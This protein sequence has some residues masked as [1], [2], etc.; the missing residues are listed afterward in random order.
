M[1]YYMGYMDY[2]DYNPLTKW[3]PHIQTSMFRRAKFLAMDRL[4]G[5]PG[6]AKGP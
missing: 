5:K 2:M 4:W 3:G 6:T 1:G